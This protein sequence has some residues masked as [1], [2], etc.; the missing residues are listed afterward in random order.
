MRS[1]GGTAIILLAQGL[2]ASAYGQAADWALSE[3]DLARL[4]Q[5]Q[6]LV[7]TEVAG[8]PSAGDVRAAVRIAAPAERIFR[9]LTDCRQALT[10]VPHLQRC[11]V[12]QSASDGSWQIV[13]HHVDYGWFLP[14]ADYVFRVEY[15][16]FE[17]IRFSNVSGDFREHEGMWEFRPTPDRTAAIVTYRVHIVPR[18][19][20]P[21]WMLRSTLRRDL[22][23]M[24]QGLRTRC[25]STAESAH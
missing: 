16:P 24:M 1:R 17:R 25:E 21:R 4:D 9:T 3:A 11:Q 14:S 6:V 12:L 2:F 20:V 23:A 8:D 5:G 19:Y 15:Q 13:E 7:W 18:F 10:F 22:P